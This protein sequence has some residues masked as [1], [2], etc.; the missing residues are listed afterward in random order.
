MGPVDLDNAHHTWEMGVVQDSTDNP[1][2]DFVLRA[3]MNAPLTRMTALLEGHGG[4]IFLGDCVV[5]G[6]NNPFIFAV[7][8]QNAPD[9]LCDPQEPAR[10]RVYVDMS[11]WNDKI[12][13]GPARLHLSMFWGAG[14]DPQ[15]ENSYIAVDVHHHHMNETPSGYT[16]PA[17]IRLRSYAKTHIGTDGDVRYKWG[18]FAFDEHTGSLRPTVESASRAAFGSDRY[19]VVSHGGW[20]VSPN[21][22]IEGQWRSE[23][24]VPEEGIPNVAPGRA[25][26]VCPLRGVVYGRVVRFSGLGD[27]KRV[28][29]P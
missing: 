4:T 29:V 28:P 12:A 10:H 5:Y 14:D 21:E 15:C 16:A 27:C 19:G 22:P 8:C 3:E 24:A 23:W 11:E 7:G 18:R 26:M 25:C 1:A 17:S 20:G 9:V 13:D 2:F 6:F